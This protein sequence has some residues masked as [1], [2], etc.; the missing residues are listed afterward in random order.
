MP[1]CWESVIRTGWLNCVTGRIKASGETIM[2]SLVGDYREEHLY[3]LRQSLECYRHYQKMIRELDAE[4]K[5][6]MLR[7]PS[8]VDPA[9]KPLGKERHPR[10]TPRRAEP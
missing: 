4:V 7:L 2:K 10:K 5:C 9:T 3:V 6:R 1:S 8:K